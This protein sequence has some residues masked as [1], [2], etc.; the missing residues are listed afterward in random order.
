MNFTRLSW[1]SWLLC[2][3]TNVIPQKDTIETGNLLAIIS[4]KL[5]ITS[6]SSASLASGLSPKSFARQALSLHQLHCRNSRGTGMRMSHATIHTATLPRSTSSAST[7][8]L[9]RLP[10]KTSKAC[11]SIVSSTGDTPKETPI[12]ATPE[13]KHAQGKG[14]W[15]VIAVCILQISRQ[16]EC[17]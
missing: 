15:I 12:A 13:D 11:V 2:S 9:R 6:R 14:E 3:S 17:R 8:R 16:E 4:P 7:R 10:L 1:I 5:D